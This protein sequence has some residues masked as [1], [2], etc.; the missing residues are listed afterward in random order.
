MQASA[1]QR[2]EELKTR[3]CIAAVGAIFLWFGT[4]LPLALPWLALVILSQVVDNAIWRPLRRP[5]DAGPPG[6]RQ[7]AA[8]RLS[9]MQAAIVYGFLPVA[10]WAYGGQGD[11]IFAMMWLMGSLLHVTLHMHHDR[12]IFVCGIVPHAVCAVALPLH[13]LI[14]GASPGRGSALL[15]L[16]AIALYVGHLR[17]AFRASQRSDARLR[18]SREE[19]LERQASAEAANEAKSAFLANMSHE[20]R[21]PLNGIIGMASALD[22]EDLSRGARDKLGVIADSSDALLQVL[23]D[24]LDVSKIEAGKLELERAEFDLRDVARKTGSLFGLKAAAA[25]LDLEVAVSPALA[26]RRIGDE[27]RLIQIVQ[28]LVS[29][30]LKFTPAGGIRVAFEPGEGGH[31]VLLTVEDTG[32]GMTP[33]Q[34]ARIFDPFMQ[35]D[36]STTRR[37][38]GTGL[39]L[40]IVGA[41]VKAMDGSVSVA[42]SPGCGT[43]FGLTL[44]LEPASDRAEAAA[45]EAQPERPLAADLSALRVL[46]VDDNA[47]NR[48]VI[49]ALLAPT[50][51]ALVMAESG[52]E[53][54]ALAE[55]GAFDIILMDI[56]MPEMDGVEAMRR[57]REKQEGGPIPIIAVSAHALRHQVERYKAQGFDGYLTKPVTA[58]DLLT[59]IARHAGPAAPSDRSAAAGGE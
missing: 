48:M 5:P 51:A 27:H 47:V 52:R 50:G 25:G 14:T 54:V 24:I 41:L 2:R 49:S 6:R 28:N 29:N 1:Q 39:G 55:G 30:A 46:A 53:A 12:G 32:I 26:P 18:A 59:E 42:S 20:I 9:A 3:I 31:A 40:A 38:G 23:N 34:E 44:M 13:S 10:V 4:S 21:T 33:E 35:A 11:K 56:S 58:G 37:Y 8:I 16:M 15:I 45:P 19:A 43:R 22:A 17:F 7:L 57:I 36:C